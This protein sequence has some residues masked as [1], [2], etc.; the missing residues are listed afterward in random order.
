MSMVKFR[1]S[2][3]NDENKRKQEELLLAD[4][5]KKSSVASHGF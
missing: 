4:A 1:N 2:R 5:I 3:W